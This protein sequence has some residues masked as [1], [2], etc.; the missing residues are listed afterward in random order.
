MIAMR[1]RFAL[2]SIAVCVATGPAL[3][4]VMRPDGPSSPETGRQRLAEPQLA[5]GVS[6]DGKRFVCS[7]QNRSV[8][9]YSFDGAELAVLQNAPGGWC[10]CYSPDG[11]LIAGCGLDR[12]IRI[13]DAETGREL[14]QLQGHTQIAWMAAFLPQGDRL[15][16][17]GE[18]AT[19]RLW[20]VGTGSEIGQLVGH[21]GPVWCM[22][23][24]ADGRWLATGAAD[25]TMRLWE[26]AT[27]KIIRKLDG[28]HGG[29]VGAL[30]FA[31]DARTI[32]STGWQD[33]KLFLWEAS[34]GRLRR[35]VPHEGGSKFV[36]FAPDS[37]TLITAGNDRAIRFWDLTDGTQWPPLEGHSGAVNGLALL[38]G[39]HTLIS[40]SNDQTVRTWDLEG[41]GMAVKTRRLPDRQVETCWS[42]LARS[43]GRGAF[44]AMADLIA[45][46][47]Q[48]MALFRTRLKAAQSPN[49]QKIADLVAQ[50]NDTKYAVR[51][52]ATRTL[53]KLGEEAEGPLR[54]AMQSG[55]LESRRRAERLL[56]KFDSSGVSAET[57]R[58][59]RA[60]EVLERIATPDAKSMLQALAAGTPEARLTLEAQASLKRL[61]VALALR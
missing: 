40:V 56:H 59:L 53:E 10:V 60:V 2:I 28:L 26:T 22:A 19:I 57:M 1:P 44:D 39:G 31:A 14:R 3:A 15:L 23:I 35:Q 16:S 8:R 24:S 25:G 55:P 36:L 51:E 5:V 41:R 48:T 54:K 4:Q 12:L 61:E 50:T 47:E 58:G 7:G 34:T 42:A 17:V 21:P 37:R 13:W 6:P 11:K 45:A 9:Q 30:C 46:P 52:Q 38:P 18:D 27:G 49:Q 33:H 43:D 32:A 20:D 29:G